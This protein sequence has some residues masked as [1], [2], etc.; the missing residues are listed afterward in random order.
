[1]RP[2]RKEFGVLHPNNVGQ[3]KGLPHGEDR[4]VPFHAEVLVL[5]C[6]HTAIR[7]PDHTAMNYAGQMYG[8]LATVD[9]H[10]SRLDRYLSDRLSLFVLPL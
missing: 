6:Y 2:G 1:M 9:L 8:A 7:G 5:P 4:W 3:G 10:M